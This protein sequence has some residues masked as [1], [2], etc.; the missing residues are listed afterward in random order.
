MISRLRNSNNKTLQK[1]E[2]RRI[3]IRMPPIESRTTF[4]LT[5]DRRRRDGPASEIARAGGRRRITSSARPSAQCCAR[6]GDP[7][8]RVE[9]PENRLT[10]GRA[11][12]SA[13]ARCAPR[14]VPLETGDPT[15]DMFAVG[16]ALLEGPGNPLQRP[17]KSRN[18]LGN[19]RP[20]G[21]ALWKPSMKRRSRMGSAS[22]LR[23]NPS[24]G[25]GLPT[26]PG[27]RHLPPLRPAKAGGGANAGLPRRCSDG[28]ACLW[29]WVQS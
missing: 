4:A 27:R 13:I 10:S 21:A 2:A 7:L 20:T 15:S 12:R 28:A 1:R 25:G 14:G 19:D 8:Q 29:G 5:L 23:V 16:P 6:P 26:V 24:S 11:P 3:M 18:P 17:E 9:K 22:L